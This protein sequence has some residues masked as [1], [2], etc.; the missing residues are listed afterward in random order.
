MARFDLKTGQSNL[1]PLDLKKAHD[2]VKINDGRY[3][4]LANA[5][6]SNIIHILDFDEY[7]KQVKLPQNLSLNGH[8]YYDQLQNSIIIPVS[9]NE[10]QGKGKFVI[11]DTDDYAIIDIIDMGSYAPHDIQL[12]DDKT[13]A[14]CNYNRTTVSN[15]GNLFA[16]G[17]H[18][19]DD[20]NIASRSK[21]FI[22]EKFRFYFEDH[23]P[24]LLSQWSDIVTNTPIHRV[25]KS[26]GYYGLP[27]FPVTI[28]KGS[29]K[30]EIIK[31]H[32]FHHRR[33]Q[34]ICYVPQ[35]NTVCMAFPHSDSILLYNATT[36]ISHYF[37]GDDLNL[38]E[39]RGITSIENTPFLAVAGIRRGLNI[40]NT[41]TMKSIQYYDV[42]MGRIIHMH[43]E[44]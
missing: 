11:L 18:D 6:S 30:I 34:S 27:I 39:M 23:H 16:I 9:D 15:A 41:E 43:H 26:N 4:V 33:A 29:D 42:M 44:I 35:T 5:M 40:I 10:A 28:K 25:E 22:E 12:L 36:G 1:I 3:I 38:K 8:A 37:T 21:E 20:E 19:Y 7:Q 13:F 17:F 14:V 32:N 31:F 24:E 2:T